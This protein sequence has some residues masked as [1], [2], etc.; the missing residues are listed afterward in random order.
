VSSCH[1]LPRL[2]PEESR[3]VGGI[4]GVM[5]PKM[6]KMFLGLFNKEAFTSLVYREVQNANT[7]P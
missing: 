4:G 1:I 5:A 3:G 7:W 2:Y 6:G